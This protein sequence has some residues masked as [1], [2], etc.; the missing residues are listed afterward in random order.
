VSDYHFI[1]LLIDTPEQ[2]AGKYMGIGVRDFTG[3]PKE[4]LFGFYTPTGRKRVPS[5]FFP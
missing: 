1:T 5:R 3:R 4:C 2:V